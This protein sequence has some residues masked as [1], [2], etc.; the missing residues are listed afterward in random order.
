MSSTDIQLQVMITGASDG[1]GLETA[2]QYVAEGARVLLISRDSEKLR[3]AADSLGD[4]V[5][6]AAV[7]LT[8][9]TATESLLRRLDARGY[10]PDVLVNNAGQGLSG[11]FVESDWSQVD[12][13]L[14]LNMLA[15]AR[16]THWAARRM[17]VVGR[18][19]IVNLSAA[20]ATRPVPWF[21]AYAASKAFVTNL[22]QA[23]DYELKPHGVRVSVV[24]PPAV[25]TSFADQ[26]KADLRS[27][28]V[29][30]LF[31]SIGA[32][33]VARAVRAAVRRR[34]RSVIV[35][36]VAAIVMGTAPIMPR[37]LDLPFMSVLFKARGS[38]RTSARL[39][40]SKIQTL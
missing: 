31:P 40:P 8:D 30:K 14:E 28:L 36:P 18:G 38:A 1:I 27:T 10:T 26:K 24:H 23:L 4:S 39:A 35:G 32:A 22:S 20:V 5:E 12:S 7:D 25:R 21:A 2:R 29:L 34:R 19:T 6:V 15:L 3:A 16:L 17:K 37:V 13:M 33:T 9:R 11:R